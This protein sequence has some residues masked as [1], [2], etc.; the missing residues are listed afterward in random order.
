MKMF[1]NEHEA[2]NLAKAELQDTEGRMTRSPGTHNTMD[3]DQHINI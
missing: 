2:G 1:W 3:M